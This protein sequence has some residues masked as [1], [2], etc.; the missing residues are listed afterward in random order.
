VP[1]LFRGSDG[2]DQHRRRGPPVVGSP[3]SQ[4]NFVGGAVRKMAHVV[5]VADAIE[6][7]VPKRAVLSIRRLCAPDARSG[8]RLLPY[9]RFSPVTRRPVL[10]PDFGGSIAKVQVEVG[11]W[12]GCFH[13]IVC[14][15]RRSADVDLVRAERCRRDPPWPGVERDTGRLV[16][17]SSP[18]L[19]E[20]P[21]TGKHA[22]RRVVRLSEDD[23]ARV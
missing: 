13:Y 10:K 11:A 21:Q 2:H 14:R 20:R 23:D 16:E 22:W 5:V 3:K 8:S 9:R 12:E 6:G 7:P 18:V 19:R 4:C 1:G 15:S 17:R